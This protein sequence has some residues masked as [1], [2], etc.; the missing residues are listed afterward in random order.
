MC[1]TRAHEVNVSRNKKQIALLWASGPAPPRTIQYVVPNHS[2]LYVRS[3]I[4]YS[5]SGSNCAHQLHHRFYLLYVGYIV[6]S[7]IQSS[8][9]F[10]E[11]YM[12]L[13]SSFTSFLAALFHFYMCREQQKQYFY[14]TF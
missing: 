3:T 4:V 6:P 10:V 7:Y 12:T 14:Y 1:E 2:H 8:V 13:C 5:Q 11:E 9:L